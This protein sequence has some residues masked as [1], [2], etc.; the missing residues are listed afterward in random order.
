MSALHLRLKRRLIIALSIIGFIFIILLIRLTYLQAFA[1]TDLMEKR[2]NQLIATIPITASRGDIYDCKMEILAKDASST[3]IYARPVD[4]EDA[5]RT[6]NIL[7]EILE[8]DKEEVYEKLTD[9]TENIVLIQRKVDNNK[10]LEIRAEN[11]RGLEFGED[12][13]R[14]YKNGNF[15]PYVLGFTGVDHQGLYGVERQYDEILKGKDG[16]STYQRDARGSK[17]INEAEVKIEAIPGK[18]LQLTIDSIIQHFAERAAEKAMFENNAKRVTIMVMEPKTGNLLAMTSKPDY[19]LN[20]PRVISEIMQ[21]KLSF[22]FVKETETGEKIEKNLGEKQ[23]EMWKNPAV[24]L[25]YEPGSTFKII[26]SAAGLEEGVVTPTSQF[27]GKG[28]IMVGKQKLKCWRYPNSHGAE[29]FQEAVQ[30]SCNPVFVEVALKLGADRFY[31]YI[32]GFGF[33]EKTG[34]DLEGEEPGI[35]PPNHNVKNLSLATR[36]YGQGITVTPI[37]LITA[38]SAVANDGLLMK[39]RIVQSTHEPESNELIHTYQPEQIRQVISKETSQTLLQILESVVSEGT[40]SKAQIPGYAIGGKT[41][42]ANKV[43]DGVYGKGKYVSSFVGIAPTTNPKMVVLVII[44]EPNP[45]NNSGGQIAAP[46]AGE[47]IQDIL[48]YFNI[49]PDYEEDLVVKETSIVPEVRNRTRNEA[50]EI[51]AT[52]KLGLTSTSSNGSDI[53]IDQIPLPGL[54]VDVSTKVELI[55]QD[56]QKNNKDKDTEKILVP[57]VL[58]YSIQEAHKILKEKELNI[59]ISGSGIAVEQEPKAGE[60]IKKDAYIKVKFRSIE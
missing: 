26:T 20:N 11:I 37:Q 35:V 59:E 3:S 44:D 19:D 39:P 40:G 8:K 52:H 12:K 45:N 55:V 60:Y 46:V 25:N 14:Y 32:D 42:T 16:V 10:A 9:A 1:S 33:G 38:A 2:L 34:I 24:A 58:D 36:S 23:Q 30:D 41:G 50:A 28:Y 51:L 47:V 21:E 29:T 57:N 4:I 7:S 49:S 54:E 27:Y 31:K 13:K 53:I 22:D 15:A 5:D 18:N 56:S 17:I 48:Q 6:A 43:I